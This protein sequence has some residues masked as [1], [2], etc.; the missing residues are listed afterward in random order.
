MENLTPEQNAVGL[1]AVV[2]FAENMAAAQDVPPQSTLPA[3]Q[4]HGIETP[5]VRRLPFRGAHGA[6]A[7]S[8]TVGEGKYWY[9]EFPDALKEWLEAGRAQVA[10]AL[11]VTL[12]VFDAKGV[13]L[14][15]RARVQTWN[16]YTRRRAAEIV[17]VCVVDW[18]WPKEQYP[19]S[20]A[21]K[22]LLPHEIQAE[23]AD[24]IEASTEKGVSQERFF[25]STLF[26]VV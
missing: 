12:E 26:G 24:V 19:V 21:N 18:D 1:G 11:G 16:D 23:L 17:R 9:V 7:G 8:C 2:G 5:K 22:A 6:A 10:T 15:S 20:D 3:G 4:T 25:R 14:D 13:P